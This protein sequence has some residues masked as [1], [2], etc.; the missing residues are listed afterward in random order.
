MGSGPVGGAENHQAEQEE[1][2]PSGIPL[3]AE[4]NVPDSPPQPPVIG[5]EV[6]LRPR[7]L[8]E[9]ASAK[10]K[11]RKGKRLRL[12]SMELRG[13]STG[14]RLLGPGHVRF[15]RPE[16]RAEDPDEATDRAR[17]AAVVDQ[18]DADHTGDDGSVH[19]V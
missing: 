12:G 10:G 19:Q 11:G 18:D 8:C 16:D 5:T 14:L 1:P 6:R 9:T 4:P 15:R 17:L 3:S 2:W 7:G 13:R